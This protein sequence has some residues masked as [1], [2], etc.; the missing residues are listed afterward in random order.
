MIPCDTVISGIINHTILLTGQYLPCPS[1]IWSLTGILGIPDIDFAVTLW[2]LMIHWTLD[3]LS[4]FQMVRH[5][6]PPFC[7][8]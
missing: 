7:A 3:L 4:G 5:S 2:N 1:K 6:F 8:S